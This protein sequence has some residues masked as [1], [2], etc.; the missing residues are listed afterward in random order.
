MESAG[1]NFV[2][3][4]ASLRSRVTFMWRHR[5]VVG[6][7]AVWM[8]FGAAQAGRPWLALAVSAAVTCSLAAGQRVPLL[9]LAASFAGLFLVDAVQGGRRLE[10]PMIVAIVLASFLVGRHAPL[11]QQPWAAAGVALLLT[12]NL[13]SEGGFGNAANVVFPALFTAAPWIL[14]LTV[15]LSERRAESAHQTAALAVSSREDDIRRATD[16]E[17]LRIAHEMHDVIAH[18][19]S[20]LSLQTQVARRQADSGRSV[21]VPQ[22]VAIEQSAR[23]AMNDLRRV[24]GVLRSEADNIDGPDDGL[25]AL[26]GLIERCRTT[27]QAVELVESG[28]PQE[29]PPALSLVAFRIVQES[30]TNARRHGEEGVATVEVAWSPGRLALR[31][32]NPFEGVVSPPGN[33][34]RGMQERASLFGGTITAHVEAGRWVV[35]VQFVIPQVSRS[36]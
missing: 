6:A 35:D 20:G 29:L 12:V 26:P 33:G 17:R 13:G 25:H 31:I 21:E 4:D 16:A 8:V 11:R 2:L 3:E 22:L 15:A 36:E 32:S 30:L 18:R 7:I 9:G 5:V 24:L 27:G 14:G 10:D 23:E 28:V 19:L 34:R 1:L